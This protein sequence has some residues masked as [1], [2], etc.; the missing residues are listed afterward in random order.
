MCLSFYHHPSAYP[1]AIPI[2]LSAQS[3]LKEIL[4]SH[5]FLRHM[6]CGRS[7]GD[8]K[9]EILMTKK[10][11]VCFFRQPGRFS[12]SKK[13]RREEV[14]KIAIKKF[15]AFLSLT[16]WFI[17]IYWREAVPKGKL[18]YL[19]LIPFITLPSLPGGC[20]SPQAQGLQGMRQFSCKS[21]RNKHVFV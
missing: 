9:E 8:E 7:E 18:Y 16:N 2:T 14:Q 5:D 19:P 3:S 11:P 1:K 15:K 12:N 20:T 13:N 4:K 21:N 17:I 10:L 6:G